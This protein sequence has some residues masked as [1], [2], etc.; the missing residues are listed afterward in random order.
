ML[1][2]L[3][4]HMKDIPEAISALFPTPLDGIEIS[5]RRNVFWT[6]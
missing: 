1:T 5:E 2:P 3:G 6:L 4:L